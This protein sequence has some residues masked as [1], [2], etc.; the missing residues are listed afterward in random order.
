ML[1]GNINS[2]GNN[3]DVDS[4]LKDVNFKNIE[5]N[6]TTITRPIGVRING[7]NFRLEGLDYS[8]VKDG[9][10]C[11]ELCWFGIQADSGS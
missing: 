10:V 5:G 3:D 1:G 9:G 4:S 6:G 2:A 11:I 7:R 8:D